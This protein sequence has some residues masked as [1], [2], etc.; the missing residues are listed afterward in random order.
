MRMNMKC[1][2]TE[3]IEMRKYYAGSVNT[4]NDRIECEQNKKKEAV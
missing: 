2:K 3:K 1:G 4:K